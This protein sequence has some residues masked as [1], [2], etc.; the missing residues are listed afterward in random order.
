MKTVTVTNISER[1]IHFFAMTRHSIA[2]STPCLKN[3]AKL[4]FFWLEVCQ[5]STNCEHFWQKD[6]NR[7]YLC[8]VHPI[9]TSPNLR[10][11]TPVRRQWRTE[12]GVRGVRT[13]PVGV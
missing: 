3:W 5:I 6:G 7:L 8:E 2:V 4:L 13:H 10:Q 11:R 1:A 9:S 12:E